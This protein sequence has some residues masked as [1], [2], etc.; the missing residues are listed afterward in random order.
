MTQGYESQP[1]E[2][3]KNYDSFELR[4]YP[5]VSMA[6][7]E[8]NPGSEQNFRKLFKYISGSNESNLKI[9]MTKPVHMEKVEGKN[10]MSF[11]LPSGIETPPSPT[12]E[13]IRIIQSKE[14]YFAAIRYGGYSNISMAKYYTSLLKES[15]ENNKIVVIG[16]PIFLGYNSPYKF[17]NRRNEIVIEVIF[18]AT[19]KSF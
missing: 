8:S 10:K 6:Q 16:N 5:S 19:K 14:A 3:I 17:F 9:A 7:T 13:N 15:L 11:V 2:L 4:Y 18:K 1:Y 12:N